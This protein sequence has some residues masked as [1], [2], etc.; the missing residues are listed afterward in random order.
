LKDKYTVSVI[1]P[2]YNAEDYIQQTMDSLVNQ[3]LKGMEIICIDDG[4]TDNTGKILDLYA[5]KFPDLVKVVHQECISQ[6]NAVNR[7]WKMAHGDYIAECDADDFASLMMYEELY[8][9]ATTPRYREKA[10]VVRCGFFGVWDDGHLQPNPLNAPDDMFCVDPHV[11]SPEKMGYIFGKM[12]LLPAGIYKRSFIEENNL[13]WREGGQNYED[14]AVSF[15]IRMAAHDYRFVNDILYYYRRGN[16][17]S[18]TDTIKD[19]FAICEQYDEIE[20][21]CTEHGYP[22]MDYM[23]TRRYYDYMWSLTRT[24]EERQYAFLT[25]CMNDFRKHPAKRE[26]FNTEEDF[27]NYC[28]IKY[29]VW[30]E[31]GVRIE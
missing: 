26:L 24:P 14:T 27:R 15:K 20:R 21:Y 22:F 30:M 5:E 29:G 18:G 16:A 6:A 23:N 19:E 1:V 3:T 4:S 11:L 17:G 28:A 9:A 10:D 7:G 25:K 31:T 2:A 12:V 8:M 13:Y